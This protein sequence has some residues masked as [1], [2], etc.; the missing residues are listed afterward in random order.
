M[1][2]DEKMIK[3][4]VCIG[5]VMMFGLAMFSCGRNGISEQEVKQEEIVG[6]EEQEVI[7]DESLNEEVRNGEYQ[8]DNKN[9]EK[10]DIND[11]YDLTKQI[12][13][14]SYEGGFD[15]TL[16]IVGDD[17]IIFIVDLS[18]EEVANSITNGSW[19]DL[20]KNG[21]YMCEETVDAY[22]RLGNDNVHFSL[23]IGD[24]SID[25]VY[26][27]ILDD[28]IIYNVADEMN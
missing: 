22:R 26:L 25:K 15:Y 19:D 11:L 16:E 1:K 5:L 14:E 12:I 4:V 23:M 27:A 17:T 20:V 7:E 10:V 13:N 18:T 28:T 2:F 9:E 8:L 24:K 6:Q 3:M 21:I